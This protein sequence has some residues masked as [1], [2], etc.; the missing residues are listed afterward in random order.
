M[1]NKIRNSLFVIS[2]VFVITF[3]FL[4]IVNVVTYS[5]KIELEDREE[6]LERLN[7]YKEKID[8]LEDSSC[9]TSLEKFV[10]RYEDTSYNGKTSLKDIYNNLDADSYASSY[11]DIKNNCNITD[12]EVKEHELTYYILDCMITYEEFYN[13]IRFPYEIRVHDKLMREIAEPSLDSVRYF[14]IKR[15][16]LSFIKNVLALLE[17]KGGNYE[18]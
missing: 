10:K 8:K 12:E 6:N 15:S 1:K 2:I 9:K 17:K 18:M 5:D 11:I 14:K 16:E 13:N 3:L 7:D 4:E